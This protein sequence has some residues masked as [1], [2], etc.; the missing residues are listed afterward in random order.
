M[1]IND[2]SF[3]STENGIYELLS[4]GYAAIE[5]ATER[6]LKLPELGDIIGQVHAP[7]YISQV[8]S[9]WKPF[10]LRSVVNI[11]DRIFEQ[12]NRTECFTQMGLF[13]EIQRAW[14]TVDNRLFLWDY[15]SGQNF[16]AYE[17]LSHT[18]VN[19]KLVRPKANVFVS[20]IQHL[21]VIATSQEM[22]LLGVTID[23]KTGELSFFSTG[24]QISVQGINVNCIV[25]SEDGRIFF[26]G[27]KDPNL[28][29]FSYQLEEGWFSRRCS[30]INITGSVFD[31]FIPSFFS[32]GTHGD[33]IK[34]IAVDDSR[35][36][37]YV[38]RE[39]S[40]VSCYELTK[41]GV[42]RCVFYSFSSMISQAQML[43]ATSPLLDPRTT[44]I[45]SI[46]PIP[47]YESQQIYCVAITSTG[48]RFYMRGGRGPISHY[49]PSN[50]TLSSTPPSTLQ[51]T[52]VR[53]PPPMQVENYTSS[54][55]YPANPFFL[56]NQSTSQQQP[57][58]SS[59]VKTTPMKCSSLS[60]IYT[61]DL[62]FAISSSNTNEGDVVCCTAP[63]VGRIA[64]AWQSGTQPSLIES[65]MYV[66]IKG[67]V[68]D[69]KC[70]QNSRERNELVSQFNTPP[71]TF[72]I[73]TNT[74]VYVVVHRRPI[75][76]LAS[77]I[78]MGPSLSSGIDGQVQLFFESVGRAEG[79]ATCLGIVSGCLDQGDFSHA[80]ANFSGSTTKLAQ[81]DLLDIVKKYY[82]E[83]GGKAFIDQSRYNNQYDS[84]SLE[85]V[86]LS[87]CHDGLASSISRII[88]NVWKNHVI[89]AKKMQN[90][91]I[92]YAPA[93]NATEILKIQS[94]LLYL[95]TFLENNKSFIE[96]L[97]SPN[98]LIGS[99]N[100]ADEIAVQAE[101]RA[102]SALLLVLQQIV[103]GISFLLF[104]N[105]TG[106]SDFHEIVSST[107]IDIQK[108]CSNMTFGEFFTSKRGREVTKELVNSLVNRHLQSG[109]NIDMVSQ[110]LRKKCGSFC[111]ADDVLIFKAVES[112]KK[113]K[114]TV[115]IEERQS[116]IEL[117]YTLFKKAAHVFTPE[118]LRLAVEEY[119]SL[120]AY[121]TA[122]NLALHVAS[123]RDDRNQALSYLV[124]G[125]PE[126]DPRR[127]PFESRTKCYSYIF[128]ILDSLESQMSNDSSAI[129]VDVYDTI[130]RS[131]DELFH[132]CFYDWYSFK[133]L[134]DRL[135]E[136]DSPY[137]QSY[138]ERNSTKDMKIADLLWQYYAKRE[139]YYQA[140]I[141][142]YDLATT[143][144]AFSLEQR[145]EYLTRAKGFGSCHVPNSL[146]HKMNKVMLSVLE[147][148]DVASIQDDV[149]IAIRGDMRIPTLKREELSKQLDGEII[150]LSDLFNNYAD[151]LGYGE[152][153]LSIFQCA[154]YRGIN[155]ILN[156]WES[157][158]KT[159]HENAIISPVG[160]SPVEAVSS[161]LK[162]LTL[163]FS[164]SENVFPIEQ[165]I[166]ITERYAFDQQGEAV[167]T[168]W[169][170]DTFLGAGVS[171][172]LIFIVLNQL[173]DR[174]EKPW[175]GKDRLF[176][177][178]KE[179]T[180]L[181]KLWHEVSVR[182]GVAQTSKPSFDAPLVLEAIE[183]YKNALGAPDTATK[184]CKENL[185][186]LDSEIRQ[187]Y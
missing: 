171:H 2:P 29:E 158:I 182:A 54:R 105:D 104:L 28:Y 74:G 38:L 33:G 140:S 59:A 16:Q 94:G 39:T 92:H 166:D 40:S 84:S 20:E 53:F 63:E 123:A 186:S 177:L 149:L 43:N 91:R 15:L 62:F 56:Q 110:L 36:L 180:H 64:N 67:F 179:V 145:I 78:R 181:L 55:N 164:Q 1:D 102:L 175:Q 27:N 141:V 152:I 42:N 37:L 101:H 122:V 118:D 172:E 173:Y 41:N 45:V 125:M 89:I 128:E 151:P 90:K 147:Q 178:I 13:A 138:L 77:A 82:I 183:K 25:S 162:N 22:L 47:A 155:E 61:S 97:N 30:K 159:T 46:V 10:Y 167:A 143:H 83:F 185:I 79:C 120:N 31:N 153:C 70:I 117:S 7:E 6:D 146:R 69:I 111:S 4:R 157:I 71:P 116:L 184:S 3:S 75:D 124:D 34:Q 119:K 127:E 9:G 168:G 23:E 18:I 135:I 8:L 126:N 26:S 50:S 35:S 176:F 121:T 144:L 134:T 174:R 52:F 156:C 98:T 73:L 106:V 11:P 5:A 136:I 58:R 133:G 169:V 100:V 51:L 68:Q 44:Q 96:G 150:P 112:L 19:V 86:R 21:L 65:S 57:E 132:Y 76:V 148:L 14:I 131:K 130:Q 87:G 81:A 88:R 32:F 24:I 113:A 107:S 154:D 163:R 114:D 48:C 80:A 49:A 85:F 95:S 72:A 108:S 165:I 137:I 99:S 161:T 139:Q 142:L 170:I 129:K 60:N 109:G 115:D 12:Y 103:E 17:D 160:S 187:T 66:P 93:F